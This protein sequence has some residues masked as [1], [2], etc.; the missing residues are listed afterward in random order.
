MMV[1]HSELE[2]DKAA[3]LKSGANGFLH[4]A[5]DLDDFKRNMERALERWLR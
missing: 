4:K 1:T 3:S 5:I 2:A